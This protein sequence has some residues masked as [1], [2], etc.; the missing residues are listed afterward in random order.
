MYLT[1][2]FWS[3]SVVDQFRKQFTQVEENLNGSGAAVS[4]Q[5][6]HSSLPRLLLSCVKL[7]F[8]CSFTLTLVELCIYP[9]DV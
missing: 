4:L 8:S 9:R 7:F 3:F 1:S 5:R 6:K 2:F